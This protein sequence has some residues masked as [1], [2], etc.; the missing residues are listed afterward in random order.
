M[1]ERDNAYKIQ[2]HEQFFTEKRQRTLQSF[3][4]SEN[5]LN[6][7]S[8]MQGLKRSCTVRGRLNSTTEEVRLSVGFLIQLFFLQ[9]L[10][11][12]NL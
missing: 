7:N 3:R 8:D 12:R 4:K 6:R 5:S 1:R 9:T 11:G 2:R 10:D